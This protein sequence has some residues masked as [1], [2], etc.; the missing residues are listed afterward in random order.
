[1]QL[2]GIKIESSNFAMVAG[3][4]IDG[5]DMKGRIILLAARAQP[6]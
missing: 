4:E 3:T 2:T 6:G 5:K 1:M